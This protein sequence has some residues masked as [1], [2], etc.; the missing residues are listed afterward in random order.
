[1]ANLN[2]S[3]SKSGPL[4]LH[5]K[6]FVSHNPSNCRG[7]YKQDDIVGQYLLQR[8]ALAD[9]LGNPQIPGRN[10][11]NTCAG[12][13]VQEIQYRAQCD[14]YASRQTPQ[15]WYPNPET[16]RHL[17][18]LHSLLP[19]IQPERKLN[20]LSGLE[21]DIIESNT[22]KI[23]CHTVP[24]KML[25]LFLGREIVSKFLHTVQRVQNDSWRGPPTKQSMILPH[26]IVSAAA[27]TILVSWMMRACKYTTMYT[28]KQIRVPA[29][30][31]AACSLAQTMAAFGLHRDSH[32][33]DVIISQQF[34]KRPV[35][36]VEVETL[37]TCL[38]ET[39]KYVYGC[40]KA[41][42]SQ[43]RTSKMIEEFE[44][45]AK[46]YPRL[47]ARFCDP[48]LNEE[49]R[50]QFG[51]EWFKRLENGSA[52]HYQQLGITSNTSSAVGVSD[53]QS[54]RAQLGNIDI[55]N[56]VTRVVSK[57]DPSASEFSPTSTAAS[58]PHPRS[59]MTF[60]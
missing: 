26:G 59:S 18:T 31:F 13:N 47:D 40:I 11:T 3:H 27:L 39:S 55:T 52:V 12:Y 15:S 6:I 32:R 50:P 42:T 34:L 21:L 1:M 4:K 38:G 25:V 45:L 37:W 48:D 58:K 36:A 49:Y 56:V 33:I 46:R 7:V 14:S 20:A 51:R 22:G 53:T 29:H 30:L 44:E 16:I 57:L 17:H 9:S 35:Y 41:A 60:K 19:H 5:A 28:M 23:L 8:A 43:P 2:L 54:L 24:K 10:Y